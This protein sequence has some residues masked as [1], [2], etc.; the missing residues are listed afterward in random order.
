MNNTMKRDDETKIKQAFRVIDQ[1]RSGFIDA[2][3]LAHLLMTMGEP[4]TQEEV[5][6][7]FSIAV[8]QKK[9]IVRYNEYAS[10]LAND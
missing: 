3:K 2:S 9:G 4:F 5:D 7:M 6:E 1:E 8:D 10:V